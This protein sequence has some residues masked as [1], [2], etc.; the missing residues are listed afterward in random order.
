MFAWILRYLRSVKTPS[1]IVN[2]GL[3][4]LLDNLQRGEFRDQPP[5]S[6]NS[7]PIP[8]HLGRVKVAPAHP[9]DKVNLAALVPAGDLL[10]AGDAAVALR[11]GRV[12]ASVVREDEKLVARVAL[13]VGS[14]GVAVAVGRAGE[15][16]HAGFLALDA[17]GRRRWRRC[18]R[19]DVDLSLFKEGVNWPAR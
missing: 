1:F 8:N 11:V 16:V 10:L 4:K 14:P 6:S 3:H 12:V 7:L 5:L 2:D 15:P 17:F 13:V 9:T 18:E 19:W